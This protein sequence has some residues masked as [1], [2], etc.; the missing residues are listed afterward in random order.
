[1]KV[2]ILK[3]TFFRSCFW[4]KGKIL[5]IEAWKVGKVRLTAFDCEF[6]DMAVV[7]ETFTRGYSGNDLEYE[8]EELK[9]LFKKL[10]EF[11]WLP[12]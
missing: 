5:S 7:N 3:K 8:I 11:N 9:L 2:N 12:D 1:L 10:D 4:G 6:C